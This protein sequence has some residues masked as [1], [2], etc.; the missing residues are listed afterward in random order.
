M[1]QIRFRIRVC[2]GLGL[3]LGLGFRIRVELGL[4]L[5]MGSTRGGTGDY[6]PPLPSPVILDLQIMNFLRR[7]HVP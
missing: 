4:R 5:I 2:L 6:S 7:E 1:P 3:R